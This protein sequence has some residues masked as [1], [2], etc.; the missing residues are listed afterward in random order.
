MSAAEVS[1]E[2]VYQCTGN[3]L[4]RDIEECYKWLMNDTIAEAFSSAIS[5]VLTG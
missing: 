1:Q 2:A 4:P 3:P 5:A